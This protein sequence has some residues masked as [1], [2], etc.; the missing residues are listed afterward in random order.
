VI[1]VSPFPLIGVDS[2]KGSEFI[3]EHLLAYCIE[4]Q[5]SFT[6][7]RSGNKND[8]A[9]VEQ[10]NWARV[11]EPVGYLRYDTPSELELLNQ[12]WDLA[13]VFTNY[14]LPQQKLVSRTRRGAKVT[15]K[16]DS[17]KTPH[18]RAIEHKKMRKRPIITLNAAFKRI[19]PAALS[20]QILDHTVRLEALSVAKRPA[21]TKP[22][23]NHGWDN[24]STGE[25]RQ[26]SRPHVDE[27]KLVT[28]AFVEFKGDLDRTKKLITQRAGVFDGRAWLWKSPDL[29]QPARPVHHCRSSELH[30]GSDCL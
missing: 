3:N 19:K 13:R 15:K 25:G 30:Y 12:I 6:R 11:R 20:K 28:A 8:G 18:R 1:S 22:V 23:V 17:S 4:H 29:G 27:R 14:L 9:H 5:I 26:M 7:S 24:R 2:D 21:S 16:H 10:K